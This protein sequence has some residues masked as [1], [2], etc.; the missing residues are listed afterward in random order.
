MSA[1]TLQDW[2]FDP[3]FFHCNIYKLTVPQSQQFDDEFRRLEWERSSSD[4]LLQLYLNESKVSL[5]LDRI[6][7]RPDYDL[8]QLALSFPELLREA[9]TK[10][11]QIMPHIAWEW[12]AFTEEFFLSR[13]RPVPDWSQYVE[14]Q[15]GLG[16][17]GQTKYHRIARE[18]KRK[19]Q[20]ALELVLRPVCGLYPGWGWASRK[21]CYLTA[22]LSDEYLL[23][24]GRYWC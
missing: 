18:T 24:S 4:R 13:G 5:F 19:V 3:N 2:L 17:Y 20:M 8:P 22:A 7:L 6:L 16:L 14:V 1:L 23:P 12:Q 15:Q 10:N 9:L 11:P 21:H